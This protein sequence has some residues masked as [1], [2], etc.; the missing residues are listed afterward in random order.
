MAIAVCA[1]VGAHTC[2]LRGEMQQVSVRACMAQTTKWSMGK[3]LLSNE[4]AEEPR[5]KAL[6]HASKSE[7]LGTHVR[8]E[9]EED[10]SP[11]PWKGTNGLS[12]ETPG[13]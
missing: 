5:S 11:S 2:N 12:D 1:R 13:M 9:M 6:A 4:L 10:K 7:C 3:T 8:A